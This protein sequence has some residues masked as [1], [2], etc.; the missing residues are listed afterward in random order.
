MRKPRDYKAEFEAL[1]RQ[2]AELRAAQRAQLVEILEATRA[3]G[4]DPV[5]LAGALL[6]AVEASEATGRPEVSEAWR[7]RGEEFFRPR[8]AADG[9]RHPADRGLAG[10]PAGAGPRPPGA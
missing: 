3:D 10:D 7:R 5:V 9:G 6:A 8:R 4:L 1:Q 2:Q